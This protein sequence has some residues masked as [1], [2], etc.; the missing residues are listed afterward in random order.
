M[1]G[2]TGEPRTVAVVGASND[3][4]KY[5]NKALRAHLQQGWTVYAVNPNETDVEGVPTYPTLA[6]LPDG[7]LNRVTMYVPPWISS[8]LLPAIA[9]RNADEVWF[10]PGSATPKVIQKAEELGIPAIEGCSIL[11]VGVSPSAL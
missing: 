7:P 10:N 6:D 8:Q 3:R 1:F 11:D 4:R 9:A 2:E 5:G